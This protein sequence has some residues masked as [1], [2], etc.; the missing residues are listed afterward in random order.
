[1][2]PTSADAPSEQ[3]ASWC[4]AGFDLKK[5]LAPEYSGLS[6]VIM[7]MLCLMQVSASPEFQQA[8]DSLNNSNIFRS[9][10]LYMLTKE[11]QRPLEFKVYKSGK[12]SIK[13]SQSFHESLCGSRAIMSYLNEHVAPCTLAV[14]MHIGSFSIGLDFPHGLDYEAMLAAYQR[15]A[16]DDRAWSSDPRDSAF[17]CPSVLR[18]DKQRAQILI[19]INPD[20]PPTAIVAKSGKVVIVGCS[21]MPVAIESMHRVLRIVSRFPLPSAASAQQ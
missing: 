21:S 9:Y 5:E 6:P 14:P 20:R 11:Y 8:I 10:G 19:R 18:P 13:G 15:N 3:T 17:P 1:M 7:N 4:D 12:I 16:G 2:D